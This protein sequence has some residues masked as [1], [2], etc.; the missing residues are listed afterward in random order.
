MK[1]ASARSRSGRSSASPR[2]TVVC[3]IVRTLT[4]VSYSAIV[5]YSRL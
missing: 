5:V 2:S 1:I 3:M 4:F